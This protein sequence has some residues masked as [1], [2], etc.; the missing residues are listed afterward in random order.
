MRGNLNSSQGWSTF[1]IKTRVIPVHPDRNRRRWPSRW[2]LIKIRHN[3]SRSEEGECVPVFH[4]R[5]NSTAFRWTNVQSG[6]PRNGRGDTYAGMNGL[7]IPILGRA[8]CYA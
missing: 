6:F 8:Y 3:E 4:V 7:H 2:G 5:V 1:S